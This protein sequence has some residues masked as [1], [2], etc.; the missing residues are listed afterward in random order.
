ML[1][2]SC[3][4][5]FSRSYLLLKGA[6]VI[7]YTI[8]GVTLNPAENPAAN[9]FSFVT[10]RLR[11]KYATGKY[12]YIPYRSAT[13]QNLSD[14]DFDLSRSRK[15]KFEGAIG[16]PIYSFLLMFNSDIGPN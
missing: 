11:W 13:T 6:V 14:L 12:I 1:D 8:G 9:K 5:Q 15:V 16:L 4:H 10:S 2:L 7:Y 3:N